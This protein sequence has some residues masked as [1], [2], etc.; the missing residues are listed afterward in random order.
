MRSW[1]WTTIMGL[2]LSNCHILGSGKKCKTQNSPGGSQIE[3]RDSSLW[4][5]ACCGRCLQR[6]PSV[7]LANA[8]WVQSQGL[9]SPEASPMNRHKGEDVCW[10]YPPSLLYQEAPAPNSS[11]RCSRLTIGYFLQ[12]QECE[13]QGPGSPAVAVPPGSAEAPILLQSC[14]HRAQVAS[15]PRPQPA[16]LQLRWK[17]MARGWLFL[18]PMPRICWAA[19]TSNWGLRANMRSGGNIKHGLFN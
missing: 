3:C 9:S 11:H 13:V 6:S 4:N 17:Q 5:G 2:G 16:P 15:V 12:S 18:F 8:L 14:N 19:A 7:G 10:K 1:Q